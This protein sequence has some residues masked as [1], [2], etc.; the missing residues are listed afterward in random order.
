MI[1]ATLDQGVQTLSLGPLIGSICYCFGVPPPCQGPDLS[2]PSD[3]IQASQSPSYVGR[4]RFLW[5]PAACWVTP[6]RPQFILPCLSSLHH[7]HSAGIQKRLAAR[8]TEDSK[9][10]LCQAADWRRRVPPPAILEGGGR[11]KG[12]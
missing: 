6:I 1:N 3:G 9:A 12:F 10:L 2:A 7:V 8:A 5:G 11:G 4:G